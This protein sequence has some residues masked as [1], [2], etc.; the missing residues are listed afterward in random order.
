[1][2]QKETQNRH[3]PRNGVPMERYAP[4]MQVRALGENDRRF[5]LSFSSEIPYRWWWGAEILDHDPAAVDLARLQSI[6]VVLYNHNRNAV[7]GR[8][9][10]ARIENA[11]GVCEMVFDEDE[12]S[13]I[14]RAKVAAGTLK[15]T[16][17]CYSVTAREEVA[18][19]ETSKDGR[20]V[21]P[22]TIARKWMPLEVSIVSIPAD[23][24]VGVG[25]SDDE[26]EG[27]MKMDPT[28][29][30][31]NGQ[32]RDDQIGV[33]QRAVPL[34]VP[35]QAAS[36]ELQRAA[37]EAARAERQRGVN[38]REICR[39]AGV[40]DA[41]AE[42]YIADNQT[43]DQVREAVLNQL[44][45]RNAPVSAGR[46]IARGEGVTADEGDKF[47]DAAADALMLRYLPGSLAKPAE[48]AAE[49]RGFAPMRMLERALQ[50]DGVNT[51]N[52]TND[53][54]ISRAFMAG[55][56]TFVA[57]MDQTSGKTVRDAYEAAPTTYQQWARI[58]SLSDFKR[59]PTYRLGEADSLVKVPM[60]GEL[61]QG[62]LLEGKPF[63]RA[64][65]T[66]GKTVGISRQ[67]LIND[68]IGQFMR[69]LA[70]YAQTA[71]R[72][73]N[74]TAYKLLTGNQ[75]LE[76]DD[77]PLFHADHKNLGTPGKLS[78]VT[79]GQMRKLMRLQTGIDEKTVLN[80]SPRYLLVPANLEVEA[81]QLLHSLSDPGQNNSGVVNVLKNSLTPIIDAELD[82]ASE[83]EYY[84]TAD[85][86]QVDGIGVDFLNG[87]NQITVRR[88]EPMGQ[89]GVQWDMWLD[90]GA[91]VGDYRGLAKNAGA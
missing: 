8:I 71:A 54:M 44:I 56:G 43:V 17:V 21:G 77:K 12:A 88:G 23:A 27:M 26:N 69:M 79:L 47:R 1:M 7:I 14:I 2:S 10:N 90:Y 20:F 85:P 46:G 5:E 68:D 73:V 6:G 16:S 80:L 50:Q 67:M 30:N 36:A 86:M 75:K 22:C 63:H 76:I 62:K 19:G 37:E 3:P 74:R 34:A 48:G 83:K 25:R 32:Q 58:G 45:Q 40:E 28:L 13:E 35:A 66:Y 4:D 59:V 49:L 78:T 33:Q 15:A 60:T 61:S 81:L 87:V 89:L 42:R 29:E 38:I 31:E 91:Y 41:E 72:D 18:N 64:L 57:I 11:R 52:M 65:E 24:S 9:E 55:D 51:R 70:A 82:A 39:S 53:D 84:I